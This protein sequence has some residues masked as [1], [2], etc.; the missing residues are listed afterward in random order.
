MGE[1]E[2]F[3]GAHG[4][5]QDVGEDL[6]I[7]ELIDERTTGSSE[8]PQL[9]FD[10]AAL[11]REGDAPAPAT[12]KEGETEDLGIKEI[13]ARLEI[14]A[15]RAKLGSAAPASDDETVEIDRAVGGRA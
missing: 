3:S 15:E 14:A 8:Y 6:L 1:H 2:A 11:A 10:A 9:V 12:A 4:A 5:F 13:M 7:A